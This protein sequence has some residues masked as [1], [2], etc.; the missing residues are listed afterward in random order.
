LLASAFIQVGV[1]RTSDKLHSGNNL[2]RHVP[3]SVN[4][5]TVA[6]SQIFGRASRHRRLQAKTD[7]PSRQAII[8]RAL[9]GAVAD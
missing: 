4:R 8:E 9:R 5:D 7:L 1:V 2:R 3:L 6:Q